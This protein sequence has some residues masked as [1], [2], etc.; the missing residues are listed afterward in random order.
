M[1]LSQ[2]KEIELNDNGDKIPTLEEALDTI[3]NKTPIIIEIINDGKVDKFENKIINIISKYIEKYDCYNRVAVMSI[4][5]LTLEYFLNNFPYVT[6]I[7]KSANFIE[8]TYGSFKTKKLKKLKYYKITQADFISYPYDLLPCNAISKHK[9]VGVIAH[10]ITNQNQYI[11][12]AEHCD[13]IIFK[14][15]KP[16]I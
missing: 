3:E 2:V 6:R 12:V 1:N 7:L 8:K 14:N 5:P 11:S 15:F 9:P 13:N 10:G 16:S 4:N